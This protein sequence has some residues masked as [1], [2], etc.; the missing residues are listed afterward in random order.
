VKSKPGGMFGSAITAST[1]CRC[2]V[3]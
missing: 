2:N 3:F 1:A